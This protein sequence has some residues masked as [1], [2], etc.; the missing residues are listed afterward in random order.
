MGAVSL[1]GKDTSDRRRVAWICMVL[2]AGT[3][4]VFGRSIGNGFVN[5]DDPDYV[6]KNVHVQE[7]LG[8]DGVQWAFSS[9]GASNLWHPL[10][11][12]SLMTDW[13]LFGAD[14]RGHHAVSLGWHALNAVLVFLLL[15]RLTGSLW[16]SALCAAL[17]AWHPLRVESVAWV[18]ERKDVLSGFFGLSAL[19]AYANYALAM[20]DNRAL[21]RRYYWLA[22]GAYALGLMCKP[23]IV[24]LPGVFLL[25]DFWPLSR[26]F[27]PQAQ[28]ARPEKPAC[29]WLEKL[30]FV[31]LAAFTS[32]VTYVVQRNGGAVSQ[33]LGLDIRLET[34]AIA[35]PRYLWKLVCPFDLSVLYPH[36]GHWPPWAVLGSVALVGG[37]TIAGWLQR[38]RR[39]WIIMGWLWF[40]GMLIPVSGIVQSGIQSMG[41]RYSY[42][43]MLGIQ[44]AAIWS[45]RELMTS[46]GARELGAIAAIVILVGLAVRTW[47]QIGVWKDSFTLFDHAIAVT[48]ANYMA[49]NNRGAFFEDQG[50]IREAEADFR[51]A[52]EFKPDFDD[53]NAN[54]GHLLDKQGRPA[55]GLP[56]LRKA[57]A[58]N[59]KMIPAHV[60]LG[61][62][63]CDLG[64]VDE[65]IDEYKWVLA[66]DPQNED[67]LDD[68]G[69]ALAM[70]GRADEAEASIKAALKIKPNDASAHGNLGNVHSMM[71]R[72]D[73]A[74][75][76]YRR[77]L[78]IN[79][80][81]AETHFN[82]GTALAQK[83]RLPEAAGEYASALK[84]RPV[85]PDAHARLGLI[86][87]Q[88]GHKDD[89]IS[90]LEMA[91]RQKPDFNQAQSWLRAVRAMPAPAG[92]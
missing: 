80:G 75:E 88:M 70:K 39:P 54:V 4:L 41:D 16:P 82:L 33:A 9:G 11:W 72:I 47:D 49:Y 26:G 3:L 19:W 76:D 92:R 85:D 91:I 79:P 12:V 45:M 83:G 58:A 65:A 17:F 46:R 29:I 71:G 87:A 43:P 18:S 1:P 77:S 52:L 44:I 20:P 25:L 30:P 78:T 21:A 61:E 55:D 51:R 15:R 24:T 53:A 74:I 42:L 40:L 86:L 73:E 62:A 81:A 48:D 6:T 50:R 66:R 63:L 22:F 2:F 38:R 8:W 23:M 56:Y 37:V 13:T 90:E 69:V 32:V 59:P 5:Y 84:L 89:A 34:A 67:A 64:R 28:L 68:Y 60:G 7:G 31:A 35:V 14:P 57:I 27:A 36:P 10:T